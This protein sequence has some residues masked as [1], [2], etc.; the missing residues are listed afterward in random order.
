MGWNVVL[1]LLAKLCA[2][3]RGCISWE[4]RPFLQFICQ[5]GGPFCNLHKDA[6]RWRWP[7]LEVTVEGNPVFSTA[8]VYLKLSW[9]L[10]VSSFT[11]PPPSPLVGGGENY[12][13]GASGRRNLAWV[14]LPLLLSLFR[15][16]AACREHTFFSWGWELGRKRRQA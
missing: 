3:A 13:M 15:A 14:A 5:G 1:A 8:T 12:L 6:L 2:P 11:R 16:P 10:S 7:W 4:E 9:G